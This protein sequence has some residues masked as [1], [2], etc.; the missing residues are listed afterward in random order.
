[1]W[2]ENKLRLSKSP[3][4]TAFLKGFANTEHNYGKS[5]ASSE[6]HLCYKYVN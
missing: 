5:H 3:H 4:L 6:R 1:M 2:V